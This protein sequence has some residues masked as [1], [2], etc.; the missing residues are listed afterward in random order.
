MFVQTAI[1][2]TLVSKKLWIQ[3]VELRNSNL[4]T[5]HLKGKVIDK[6]GKS[7]LCGFFYTHPIKINIE[8]RI[9]TFGFV[10]TL[11]IR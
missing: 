10:Q 2:F 6:N 9:C 4:A 8:A 7:H 3:L 5:L 11:N 1:L